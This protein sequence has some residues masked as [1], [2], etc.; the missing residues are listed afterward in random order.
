ME[1]FVK[2]CDEWLYPLGYSRYSSS[3]DG[4]YLT[5]T[6][7]P[8]DAH[9]PTINC[10]IKENGVKFCEVIGGSSMKL[11][12]TMRSGE[13]Q[14]KHPRIEDWINTMIKYDIEVSK[15]YQ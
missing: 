14:F 10:C 6:A 13:L 1:A 11:F 3:G 15:L 2:E 7:S 4:K 5:Y 12:I 8:L 9:K